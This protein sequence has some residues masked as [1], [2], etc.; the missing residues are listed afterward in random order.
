MRGLESIS[1]S[2]APDTT[3]ASPREITVLPTP[4]LSWAIPSTLVIL[5]PFLI[6]TARGLRTLDD[7]SSLRYRSQWQS[8]RPS[9][10]GRLIAPGRE[11]LPAMVRG[12]VAGHDQRSGL[13]GVARA[14]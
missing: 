10:V 4:P 1:K 2:G 13:R 7:G 14:C 11:S 5:D 9:A 3:S 6:A 8:R 12:H